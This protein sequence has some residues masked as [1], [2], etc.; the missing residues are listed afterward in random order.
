MNTRFTYQWHITNRCNL[1]CTH[2]YQSAYS[3]DTSIDDL[4]LVMRRLKSFTDHFAARAHVNLTGGEPI[5]SPH[6]YDVLDML[7]EAN[8]TVGLLTNGTLITKDIAKRLCSYE[9]LTYVQVS[10]DGGRHTHDAERGEGNFDKAMAGA[11]LIRRHRVPVYASF[12]AQRSNMN[13]LDNAIEACRKAHIDYFWTDR[14]IPFGQSD[15]AN[16]MNAEELRDF[17]AALSSQAQRSGSVFSRT[18][19]K[20]HR[21]LQ[22]LCEADDS[23]YHCEAGDTFFTIDEQCRLLP[24]RRM[25]IVIGSLK[26]QD[27]LSLYLDHPV[28]QQLRRHDIPEKCGGCPHAPKC[29]GGLKCLAYAINGDFNTKDP[30]CFI[31]S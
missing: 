28:M 26:E 3:C 12:T 19:V 25:P 22:F 20:T 11:A 6:L 29:R 9:N 2:C 15:A 16:C 13:E 8:M 24:C 31:E 18:Y 23:V 30:A 5:C 21:A 7:R 4:R 14:L 10:V 27:L 1:R 17:I